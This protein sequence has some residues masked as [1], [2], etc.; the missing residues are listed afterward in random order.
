MKSLFLRLSSV[1]C[2]LSFAVPLAVQAFT[3]AAVPADGVYRFTFGVSATSDGSIPVPANAVYDVQGTYDAVMTFTYGFLGTTETSYADDVPASPSCAEPRAIDG[4][5]VVQGQQIVLHDTNDANS[6][7][8]ACGPAAAEYLPLGA[9]R[10]EGRYPIRFA[11]RGE[12]RAYYAVTCTVANA[13]STT[14]ADV[15]IFSERTHIIA[16]HLELG[17][18]ETRTFAWSVELAP[19]VYKTQGTYYD[20]A[21]NVVVV[22]ENA[23]LASL[24]V[25]KQ[26][27][28][29]G[30]VRGES[31]ENMNAGR[32]MW[33]CTDSTGTDQAIA[34]P[35]FSLQNYA[36]VGS[37]LS[38]WAP[39]SLSIRNQGEGGL[40]TSAGTHRRSCLL[41]PGDY[42]YVEYGH[43]ESGITSYTNNLE[44]YLADVNAAGASL[45]IVS[46]VERRTSWNSATSTWGRSLQGIA[47]AG[48]AWVEEKIA[49][50]ARN[51]AFINLNKKYN[52]WMND[53][54]H[55]I[56]NINGQVSLNAAISFYY[57]SAKGANVDN[58]HINTAGADQ[59]AYWVWQDALERVAAGENAAEGS[60]AKVQSDVLKGITEG[61]QLKVGIGGAVDNKP[62]LV[63]DGIVNAGAA[64]NVFWDTP[65]STGFA[66]VNDAVVADVA[67]V[68]NADGSLTI[69]NVTMRILN[70]NNYYKAV[71]EVY[72][73]DAL[74]ASATYYS[75]FNYDVGGAG[76]VSGDLVDPNQ[77]G[78]LTSDKDKAAVTA[79]DVESI[80]VPAGG[81]AF[82]WFAEADAGTWQVGSN[83]PCSPKHPVEWWGDVLLD[84]DCSSLD[85]WQ[86]NTGAVHSETVTDGAIYFTTTG[87][88]SGNTK[89][90][91]GLCHAL[92]SAM[93]YGRYR[94]SFKAMMDSGCI[95]FCLGDSIYSTTTMLFNNYET[96]AKI[97]GTTV[98]GPGATSPLV[99]VDSDGTPQ[100][101][102]NKLRW[103]DVDIVIDRDYGRTSISVGGGDFVE[104]RDPSANPKVPFAGKAWKYFGITCPGQ[105]SSYGFIDDVKV[106]RLRDDNIVTKWDFNEYAGASAV[107]ATGATTI[108]Y[109]DMEFHL[110]SGDSMT[111]AGL[112]W[113]NSAISSSTGTLAENSHYIVFTPSRSGTLEVKFSVDA[114]NKSRRPTMVVKAADSASGCVGANGDVSVAVSSANDEYAL[115]AS[116]KRGVKY[117]V[118]TYSYNWSGGGFSHNY[119]IPSIMYVCRPQSQRRGIDFRV[120]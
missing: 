37:G 116:L 18:G 113:A 22:G 61:C 56:T 46:P 58:T 30:T 2:L 33:L 69:S 48:E 21:V 28:T 66:Y 97:D 94:V 47:E 81:K 35:F 8:C 90:N 17:P 13:S 88:D 99:T 63:A 85:G 25:V 65:V 24:T 104:Y 82:V 19:N 98:T 93:T 54:I 67:A 9:S 77:P 76:K 87:A 83:A 74:V 41:K 110:K 29:A 34:T 7:S 49:H 50:G 80:T 60:V 102:A 6:V 23:A 89:K 27:Q 59:A 100:N 86:V 51:V 108:R 1:F 101:V 39:A 36:G 107:E 45:V 112:I 38:R 78:F 62:W 40:A 10:Y 4:F 70:P 3:T 43:N 91:Y 73:R 118:W 20:N 103:I 53:E 106:V 64:P 11:M 44:T 16:H 115:S 84:D 95:T 12:E 117:Y 32:T 57:R 5:S 15:T 114:Y 92:G 109:N 96:L 120:R 55:R 75:C 105:Q 68:A 14:N 52:D 71:V 119:R 111:D 42:L 31:V 79:A 26:P 72:G